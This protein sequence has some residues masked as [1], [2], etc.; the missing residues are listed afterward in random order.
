MRDPPLLNSCGVHAPYAL[1]AVIQV[2]TGEDLTGLG[3]AY[4]DDST[5]TTLR[6]VARLL[7]GLDIFRPNVLR[8][9]LGSALGFSSERALSTAFAAFEV[10]LL[11]LAGKAAGRPACDLLG[12]AVRAE[13]P[14]AG[15]LFYRWA[16]HPAGIAG[17]PDDD[18]GEAL[19]ADGIVAQARRMVSRHGFGSLKLKG[20]VPDP[21]P[22]GPH[23]RSPRTCA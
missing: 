13:V 8:E 9:R 20:G 10:P 11:D 16:R 4:G 2:R 17:Y 23:C 22:R 1:R 6:S 3:E 14:Y 18:W 7:P 19:D 15:Y 5:L 12:G 21:W